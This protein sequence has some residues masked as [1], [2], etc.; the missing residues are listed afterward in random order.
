VRDESIPRGHNQF[1]AL[2]PMPAESIPASLFG[3]VERIVGALIEGFLAVAFEW[4][5]GDA[6]AAPDL[7]V[8]ILVMDGSGHRS[9][10][11][12]T[13]SFG[14]GKTAHGTEKDRKFISSQPGHAIGM[15]HFRLD[16]RCSFY[17]DCIAGIMS[18]CVV[19]MFEEIEI[20]QQ[21]RKGLGE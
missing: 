20:D 19:H 3:M 7:K 18:E 21:K 6:N 9:Q 17:Q 8:Q 14:R 12:F 13:K 1:L 2:L 4:V 15:T 10:K 16:A 5:S 11:P